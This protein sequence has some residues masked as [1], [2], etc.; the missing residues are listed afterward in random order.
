MQMK[1]RPSRVLG[2]LRAGDTV[3]CFK[4]NLA[5]GRAAEIA[6][7]SGFDCIW[8]DMEHTPNDYS[9]VE[10]QIWAS[11]TCNTDVL[12]RV[13][14]GGYSDY[15]RPLE[16]DCAGIM[17]PHIMSLEDARDVV[18]KTRFHPIGRR[19]LDGGNADGLYCGIDTAGYTEESNRER[20][21]CVQIED[22]EPMDEL[23]EIAALP[24]IDMLFFGPGDFSHGIG[25]PGELNHPQVVEARRR[26]ADAAT[27][28]GKFAG[29][30]GSPGNLD[31][32]MAEGFRFINA[33]SDVRGLRVY[34]DDIVGKFK[35]IEAGG[36]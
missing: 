27:R 24:G 5:D 10:R 4:L 12:V 36:R 33:G 14:R 11:K 34:C 29:T 35:S 8:V 19:A 9:V 30:V 17:V 15:I 32:L 21:L 25:V 6:A 26:M 7:M 23:E 1:M 28:H 16:M 18:R 2:K 31:D 20:F 3:S 13:P 22:P